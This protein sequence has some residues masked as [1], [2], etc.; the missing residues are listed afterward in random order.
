MSYDIRLMKGDDP[1]GDPVEMLDVSTLIEAVNRYPPFAERGITWANQRWN[2]YTPWE[3]LAMDL[4]EYEPSEAELERKEGPPGVADACN[5]H[6][7]YGTE[8]DLRACLE[9]ALHIAKATG[10]Q[11]WDLQLDRALEPSDFSAGAERFE[12]W[13]GWL[14]SLLGKRKS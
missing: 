6:I 8:S 9:L 1:Y 2:E 3:G 7:S 4:E 5:M 11:A 14:R 12:R 10:A 13:R